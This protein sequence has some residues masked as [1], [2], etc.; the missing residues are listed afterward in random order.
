[1]RAARPVL[2]VYTLAVALWCGGKATLGAVVAP[3]VFRTVA[4]PASADAMTRVFRRFDTVALACALVAICCEAWLVLRARAPAPGR[5]VRARPIALGIA[6]VAAAVGASWLS[7]AIERLHLGGA[8]RGF[9]P[10]GLEL[11]RLHAWAERLAK[12]E[13]LLLVGL[14]SLIVLHGTTVAHASHG[15]NKEANVRGPEA[16]DA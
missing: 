12:G 10:D 13:L 1:M 7:P 5:L 8:V 16:Y 11:E 6:T 15:T 14:L 9:G 4:A 2:V 3:V